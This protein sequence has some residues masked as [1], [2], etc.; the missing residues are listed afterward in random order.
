V[1]F[2]LLCWIQSAQEN[3]LNLQDNLGHQ[4]R[5]IWNSTENHFCHVF[6]L[7]PHFYFSLSLSY[8]YLS[9]SFLNHGTAPTFRRLVIEHRATTCV[10]TWKL[11]QPEN[12]VTCAHIHGHILYNY[13]PI[14]V[15]ALSNARTVFARSNSGIV[16]SNPTQGIDAC[17]HLFCV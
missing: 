11:P 13:M 14:T 16:G 10:D 3:I 8:C 12:D 7:Y 2:L 1:I 4:K 15:A 6:I 9:P 17:L 5:A